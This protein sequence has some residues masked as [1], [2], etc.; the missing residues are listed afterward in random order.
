M[1]CSSMTIIASGTVS[2]MERKSAESLTARSEGQMASGCCMAEADSID[3]EGLSKY[4]RCA[5]CRNQSRACSMKSSSTSSSSGFS[6]TLATLSSRAKRT[7]SGEGEPVISATGNET[8]WARRRATS[9]SP[10]WSGM[11]WSTTRQTSS[12]MGASSRNCA[13][14]P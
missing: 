4:F 10:V 14:D 3:D 6:I 8:P 1:P 12:P 13:A 9:C 7:R 2:R 5:C 11:C